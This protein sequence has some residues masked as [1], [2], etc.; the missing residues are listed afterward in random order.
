MTP[1]AYRDHLTR[2]GF[3][4]EEAGEYFGF[5]K[6]TGQTWAAEGPPLAV[7][8]ALA[9]AKDRKELD[10]LKKKVER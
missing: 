7:A 5:S 6:R 10:R 9:G 8:M 4:Q 3:R 1:A 2:L